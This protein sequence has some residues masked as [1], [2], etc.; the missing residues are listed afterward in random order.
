VGLAED[1]GL[2]IRNG[3]ECRVIGSGM[4]IVFDPSRLQ[5]NNERYLKVGT[6]MSMTHLVVH[7][8]ANG[9]HLRL[10]DR[11]VTVL[12]EGEDFI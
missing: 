6:P 11:Q 5:H 8:L 12:P 3:T 4:V 10:S 2:I 1:T 7:I 9:D